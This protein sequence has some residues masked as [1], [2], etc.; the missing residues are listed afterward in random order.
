MWPWYHGLFITFCLVECLHP[1]CWEKIEKDHL[2]IFLNCNHTWK[3]V[4]FPENI[5]FNGKSIN[6]KEGH[7]L[8]TTD[9]LQRAIIPDTHIIDVNI[10]CLK[11][12]YSIPLNDGMRI[13]IQDILLHTSSRHR[14]CVFKIK[15]WPKVKILNL[16]KC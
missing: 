15:F 10:F 12:I 4:I 6:W 7:N 5:E 1:L 13:M 16:K 3:N 9:L 8:K 2:L 14:V 11:F